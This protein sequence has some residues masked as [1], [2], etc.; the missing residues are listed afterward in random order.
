MAENKRQLTLGS[1]FDGIAGFP[2]AAVR[3]GIK[4]VWGSEIEP[5]CVDITEKHFPDMRQLGDITKI[6]GADIPQVDIISFGSPCQNLSVAGNGKG[7]AGEASQLFF[8]A[9][10]II[11]EMRCA[12]DGQYPKYA[13]WENVAG[14]FSSNKGRDFQ[15]VLEEITKTDIP[16][17]DS[18]RWAKAGMVGSRGEVQLGEKWT[19][20]I[21]EFPSVERESILC[22][23]LEQSVPDKYFLS[24]KV[25]WAM[26]QRAEDM[27]RDMPD[28]LRI[29]LLEVIAEEWSRTQTD[30]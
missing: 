10:R 23:I 29:A 4:P 25:C 24:A 27:K 22:E 2:L 21:G 26:L 9:V 5:D 16:M 20:N 8:E 18:G 13:V 12:T 30:K 3:H 1:L 11:D 28:K 6:S 17:P 15:K 19:L 7:L 14:A